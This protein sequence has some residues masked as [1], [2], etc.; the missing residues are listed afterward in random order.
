M[1]KRLGAQQSMVDGKLSK[2]QIAADSQTLLCTGSWLS[3]CLEE[4][5]VMT[6]VGV[7]RYHAL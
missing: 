4:A 1:F 6:A 5:Y 7:F 2:S 3:E